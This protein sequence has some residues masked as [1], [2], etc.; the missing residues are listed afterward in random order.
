MTSRAVENTSTSAYAFTMVDWRVRA[1]AEAAFLSEWTRFSH[2]LS[3]YPG[4][5]SLVL[6]RDDSDALRFV[7]LGVW[8]QGGCTAPWPGFLE[9]L[10][11]CRAL[12]EASRSSTFRLVASQDQAAPEPTGCPCQT[13]AVF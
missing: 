12:C 7:S 11:R 4:V 3:E 1:G 9:R 6:V 8:S 2:W 13:G 10:G 5:E